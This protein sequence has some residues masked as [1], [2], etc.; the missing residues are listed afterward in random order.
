MKNYSQII[1]KVT[2]TPWMMEPKAL[3]MMLEILEAHLQGTMTS[4]QIRV[5]LEDIGAHGDGLTGRHGS[6]GV[7]PLYGPIFPRAD[8]MTEMSGATSIEQFQND[9]R[10]M[11]ADDGIKSIVMDIDSPGGSASMI[12]EMMAELRDARQYKPIYAIANTAANSAAYGLASSASKVFASPS[13]QVGAVG[14]YLVHDD[15]SRK[16]DREGVDQTVIKAGRFKAMHLESLT[17]ESREQLQ[18]FVDQMNDQFIEGIAAGRNT[19]VEKVREN[20]GEGAV[21]TPLKAAEVGMIDGIATFDSI[22]NHAQN[23]K[24]SPP[25]YTLT[26]ATNNTGF[27]APSHSYDADMEHSEPGTGFGG[28]PEPREPPEEGDP[29]I[30]GGW[31][32]DPPPIA[33]EENETEESVVNRDWLQQQA[34]A[35]GVE[36]NATTDDETLA[37][38][39]SNRINEVVI[40]ISKATETAHAQQEFARMY[41]EQAEK[42]ARL[43]QKDRE[44]EAHEFSEQ[45][46]G[47]APVVRDELQKAHLSV[48]ERQFDHEMLETLVTAL[49]SEYAKVP[50]GEVGSSRHISKDR[51]AVPTDFREARK[52]F[53]ELVEQAMTEDNLSQEAALDHVSKQNPELANAYLYGHVGR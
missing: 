12:P 37:E 45:F 9:F 47:Y 42:L 34:D 1:S 21:L 50:Q 30:E 43:E 6:V 48:S 29:A 14:T 22:M 32:R 13:A 18:D 11:M 41:P 33:Y 15:E 36:W 19:T 53:A 16:R 40:P 17:P 35:L 52:K 26:T 31:R 2:S 10:A 23:L 28:P 8:L 27:L 46:A 20:Y 44:N 24:P 4:D 25:L 3:K 39:V 5:R 49:S 51:D 7:L 38:A